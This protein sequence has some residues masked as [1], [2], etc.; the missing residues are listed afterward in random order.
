MI[1]FRPFH[2]IICFALDVL[3]MAV[4]ALMSNTKIE[5]KAKLERTCYL[6]RV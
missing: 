3:T 4:R 1:V 6:C 2:K 5:F